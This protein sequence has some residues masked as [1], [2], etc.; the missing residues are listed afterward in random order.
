MLFKWK[1]ASINLHK[2]VLDYPM[3]ENILSSAISSARSE[4]AFVSAAFARQAPRV[5]RR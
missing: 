4:N 2:N 3:V 1:I 5:S